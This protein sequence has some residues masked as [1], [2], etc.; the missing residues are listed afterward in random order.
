MMR[1]SWHCVTPDATDG[2]IRARLAPAPRPRQPGRRGRQRGV[3]VQES[4]NPV[5]EVAVSWT[6]RRQVP[7]AVSLDALTV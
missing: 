3:S 7:S 6:R 5:S 4:M 1:N 2:N